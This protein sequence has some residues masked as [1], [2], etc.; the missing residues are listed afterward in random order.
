VVR[1]RPLQRFEFLYP[2]V[3]A[4]NGVHIVTQ[5]RKNADGDHND[6]ADHGETVPDEA[7][8]RITPET[9]LPASLGAFERL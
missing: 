7:P 9:A 5:D 3:I 4:L 1:V 6:Q 2:R 8:E